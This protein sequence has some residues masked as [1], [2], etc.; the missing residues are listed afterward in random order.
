[1]YLRT[2]GSFKSA[3]SWGSQI[4]NLRITNSQS[5]KRLCP[6]IANP[7]V[8][9]LRKVCKSNKLFTREA[10][11]LQIFYL[12]HLFADRPPLLLDNKKK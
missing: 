6:Q 8:P 9:H 11:R 12:R 3:K 2:C 7:Q 5:Q 4:A 10:A 1:M